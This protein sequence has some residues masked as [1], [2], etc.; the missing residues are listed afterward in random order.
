M[1]SSFFRNFNLADF[2]ST[3]CAVILALT[4]HELMHGIVAYKLGDPTAKNAGRL[5]LNPIAHL[6]LIGFLCM[7]VFRFGWA[8]PVPV[9][10]RYFR[11]PRRDMALVAAAGPVSNL[12]FGFVCVLLYYA[13]ALH[14]PASSV[15]S[16]VI[17][18]LAILAA[19]NVGFAVFNLLPV[20]PLDGSRIAGLFLPPRWYWQIMR[21]ERY[22][23]I[24]VMLLL[25]TGLLTRPLT[26]AR[27]WVMSGMEAVA[28]WMFL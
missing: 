2:I 6:D 10:A 21:Y 20:P 3:L 8:K 7:V 4:V 11:H 28:Q 25:Y 9:N 17:T 18:F 26:L 12:V 14:A 1:L 27:G 23:Q 22:I 24:G 5:T 13:L 16:A 19:L 15:M